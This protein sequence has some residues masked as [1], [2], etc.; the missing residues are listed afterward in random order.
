MSIDEQNQCKRIRE[1]LD[2]EMEKGDIERLLKNLMTIPNG[3]ER[4][5]NDWNNRST[6]RMHNTTKHK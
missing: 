3:L 6:M 1:I 4:F 2:G 5:I